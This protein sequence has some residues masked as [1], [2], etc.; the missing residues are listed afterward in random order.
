MTRL[1]RMPASKRRLKVSRAVLLFVIFSV[2]AL[3][4]LVIFG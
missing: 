4:A 1:L 3:S 2:Q